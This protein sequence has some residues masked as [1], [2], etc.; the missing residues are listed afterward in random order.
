MQNAKQKVWR[1]NVYFK[2]G[3]IRVIDYTTCAKHG[4]IRAYST[5]Q[6]AV[7]EIN[8]NEVTSIDTHLAPE[9]EDHDA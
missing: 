3:A 9:Y 8:M 4:D 2:S 6:N 7:V 5:G 1:A